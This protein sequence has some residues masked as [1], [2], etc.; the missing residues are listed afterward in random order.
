VASA[1]AFTS[2]RLREGLLST[3]HRSTAGDQ[4]MVTV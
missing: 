3:R 1:D 2:E 4:L